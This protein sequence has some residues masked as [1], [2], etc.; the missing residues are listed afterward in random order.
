MAPADCS[1][2]LKAWSECV[3][4][5]SII[6]LFENH[7]DEPQGF[8]KALD[9]KAICPD[10]LFHLQSTPFTD[11][12]CLGIAPPFDGSLFVICCKPTCEPT[13]MLLGMQNSRCTKLSPA[14]GSSF[15]SDQ[16]M[17][18][19]PVSTCSDRCLGKN[20]LCHPHLDFPT[21]FETFR[22]VGRDQIW[23]RCLERAGLRR[24]SLPSSFG[25]AWLI[26]G[27]KAS[28]ATSTAAPSFLPS[29]SIFPSSVPRHVFLTGCCRF[30]W[31]CLTGAGMHD[32]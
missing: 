17:M 25:V 13:T 14:E 1:F 3:S 31:R 24:L 29:F 21:Y 9:A 20:H 10:F 15:S 12:L 18:L 6:R 26:S 22:D 16:L 30:G 32:I 28:A 2:L 5:P 7:N 23:V 27:S 11:V 19:L 4:I 8:N